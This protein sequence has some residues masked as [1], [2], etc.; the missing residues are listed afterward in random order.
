MK[1]QESKKAR[2]FNATFLPLRSQSGGRNALLIHNFA[3]AKQNEFENVHFGARVG[4][5]EKNIAPG[6]ELILESEA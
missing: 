5:W 1:L 6:L 4:K 3:P 2:D